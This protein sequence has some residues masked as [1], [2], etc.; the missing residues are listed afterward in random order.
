MHITKLIGSLVLAVGL[1]SVPFPAEASPTP[2]VGFAVSVRIAPPLLPVYVQPLCPGP[3]YIWEP[4]YWAYGDDGYYWVP[5]IWVLPPGAGLLWTPGYWGFSNGL[6]VWNAG[7]WGL[8]VG[9]YGGINYGFGYPGRG[10]HGGYWRGGRYF[11]NTRVTNVNTTIIHNVYNTSVVNDRTSNRVSFNGPNGVNA[12][13]T[14]AELSTARERHVS[15]TSAQIQH[16]RG[17]S[18]NRTLLASV[19]HGRPDVAAVARPNELSHRREAPN[20]RPANTER[21]AANNRTTPRTAAMQPERSSVHKTA[22]ATSPAPGRSERPTA[23]QPAPTHSPTPAP[24]HPNHP[25]SAPKREASHTERP[26]AHQPAPRP[27][28]HTSTPRPSHEQSPSNAHTAPHP[29]QQHAAAPHAS[30]PH[31]TTNEQPHPNNNKS[32]RPDH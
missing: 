18:T 4:G 27:A 7:Y 17:A 22:P 15:M 10:F 32:Q 28:P 13:P 16:Q 12:R 26:V 6:Y 3:G 2:R 23:H 21:L 24:S 9:F 1:L 8:S 20:N 31:P 11:Y 25:P 30:A 19:N 14:S 29:S 5:G